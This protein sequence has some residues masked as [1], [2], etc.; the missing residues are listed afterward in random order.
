M[1]VFKYME[2]IKVFLRFKV[3]FWRSKRHKLRIKTK[4]ETEVSESSMLI[5]L[6]DFVKLSFLF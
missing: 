5:E 1:T 2:N 6:W 4:Q 3:E